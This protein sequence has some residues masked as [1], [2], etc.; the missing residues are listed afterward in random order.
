MQTMT[1][2]TDVRPG[3]TIAR[4]YQWAVSDGEYENQFIASTSWAA[5]WLVDEARRKHLRGEPGQQTVHLHDRL[6]GVLWDATS[7]VA[8]V[9]KATGWPAGDGGDI[10]QLRATVMGIIRDI[11]VSDDTP[12][13]APFP[14]ISDPHTYALVCR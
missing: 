5:A 1:T 7:D 3:P 10:L 9:F 11:L 13:D 6:L 12:T 14:G 4:T 8:D 2:L